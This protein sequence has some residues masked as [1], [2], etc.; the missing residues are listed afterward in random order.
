MEF[1]FKHVLI[2]DVAYATL[3]RGLRRDLHAA[4]ARVIEGSVPDPDGARVGPRVPLAR[5]R[6]AGARARV[7]DRGRRSGAS[8]DGRGG[9]VRLL[10]ARARARGDSDADRRRIR[11]RR[12]M[13]LADLE[14]FSRADVELAEL[15][16]ELDG[17]DEIEA[18][19]ARSSFDV[20]DRAGGGDAGAGEARRRARDRER[21][22][23]TGGACDRR[24]GCQ[25][26]DAR[27]GGR[28]GT[29]DRTAG[30]RARDVGARY[31]ATGVGRAVPHA[32]RQLLLDRGL[33]AGS[34]TLA[35][36]GDHGWRRSA[37]RRVRPA[38]RRHGGTHPRRGWAATRRR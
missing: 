30:S 11:L 15:I 4:T 24:A 8:G 32:R 3:P 14:Q 36:G 26:C 33:S 22:E 37:E 16:P 9:D 20:L 7:P 34:G 10:H 21:R 2:R 18:I 31:A 28:S 13:A 38:W 5:G 12:G 29:R 23:G 17:L 27:R 35:T 19:L 1:A 6:R 25:L